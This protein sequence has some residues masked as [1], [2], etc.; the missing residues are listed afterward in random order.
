MEE[1]SYALPCL[2]CRLAA[3]FDAQIAEPLDPV[4]FESALN[5]LLRA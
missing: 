5:G 1:A 2:C 4:S 3:G